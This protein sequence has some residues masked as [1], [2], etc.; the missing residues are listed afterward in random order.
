MQKA[1]SGLEILID[2]HKRNACS[3]IFE[4][5]IRMHTASDEFLMNQSQ[6]L[7]VSMEKMMADEKDAFEVKVEIRMVNG[8]VRNPRDPSKL[9]GNAEKF[10]SKSLDAIKRFNELINCCCNAEI[11]PWKSVLHVQGISLI[12]FEAGNWVYE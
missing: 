5:L 1:D 4:E 10:K 2:E 3:S 9:E 11:E 12:L 6:V 7:L 8:D